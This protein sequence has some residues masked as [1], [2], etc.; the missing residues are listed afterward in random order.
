MSLLFESIK[1]DE[2]R[3]KVSVRCYL[4]ELYNDNLVDLLL[5]RDEKPQKLIIK[6]DAKGMHTH[7]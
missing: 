2:S 7:T 5:K 3:F 4:L 1:R 6:K